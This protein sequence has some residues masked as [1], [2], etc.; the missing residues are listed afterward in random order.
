MSSRSRVEQSLRRLKPDKHLTRLRPRERSS[1]EFIEAIEEGSL[2]LLLD[3]SVY[4]D[5]LQGKLLP[6]VNVKLERSQLWHSAVSES[7]LA[8]IL[9]LLNPDHK[10]T[11]SIIKFVSILLDGRQEHRILIP[12]QEVWR[13][14]GILSGELARLQGYGKSDRRRALNDALIFLSAAKQG[15]SVLTRNVADFDLLMQLAPF[16]KAIFYEVA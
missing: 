15:C 4:I 2:K 10:D 9:G 11:P 1:L 6:R 13:E 14:A 5:E 8:A 3:T 7:E 16:G 12:D